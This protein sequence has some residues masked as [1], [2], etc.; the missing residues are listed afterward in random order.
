V[1]DAREEPSEAVRVPERL[2]VPCAY[3]PDSD[4]SLAEGLAPQASVAN[5]QVANRDRGEQKH[6]DGPGD[7]LTCRWRGRVEAG[8]RI[9]RVRT[10]ESRGQATSTAITARSMSQAATRDPNVG[11]GA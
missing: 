10:A 2:T 5:R 1:G 8:T 6:Q 4:E 11:N 7:H 3:D 9:F